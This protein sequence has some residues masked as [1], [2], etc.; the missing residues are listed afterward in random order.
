M[1][2][3]EA[4]YSAT[5]GIHVPSERNTNVLPW[6]YFDGGLLLMSP[7]E[8]RRPSAGLAMVDL[9]TMRRCLWMCLHHCLA[10]K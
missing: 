2:W 9:E 8:R 3:R 1:I 6:E 4:G 10:F 7:V 5:E